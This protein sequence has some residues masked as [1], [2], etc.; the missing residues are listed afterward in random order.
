MQC[1]TT[2]C[3]KNCGCNQNTDCASPNNP[4]GPAADAVIAYAADETKVLKALTLRARAEWCVIKWREDF[5]AVWVKATEAGHSNLK[6]MAV[7]PTASPTPPTGAPSVS[8]TFVPTVAPTTAV[9]TYDKVAASVVTYHGTNCNSGA[10]STM[11][12]NSAATL[13]YTELGEC[14]A[15]C[16][17]CSDCVGFVDVIGSYCAFKNSEETL[18]SK[19]GKDYYRRKYFYAKQLNTANSGTD[20]TCSNVGCGANAYLYPCATMPSDDI[21]ECET[22]C[23]ECAVDGT[24]CVG[25][26]HSSDGI[27]TF[28]ST[29]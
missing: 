18:Q 17:S 5:Q 10:S 8:P 24:A 21:G 25:F 15:M 20:L 11:F 7:V 6:S 19:T 13:K 3:N 12:A 16:D 22:V 2:P 23:N 28:K 1:H 26:V 4:N 9:D 14:A 29:Q 27:C